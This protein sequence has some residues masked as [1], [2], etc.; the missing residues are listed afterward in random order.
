MTGEINLRGKVT[1]IGGV[2]EKS[3]GALRAGIHDIILP[4]DN[5]KDLEEV[6]EDVMKQVHFH[7][8]SEI[9]EVLKIMLAKPPRKTAKKAV[10]KTAV[11]R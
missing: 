11:R 8:V 10:R 5:R 3:I 6:P 9:R 7:F 2:K 1:A 4:E